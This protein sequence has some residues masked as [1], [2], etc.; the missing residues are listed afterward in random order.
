VDITVRKLFSAPTQ[1][2]PESLSIGHNLIQQE[3][4]A[5]NNAQKTTAHGK[6]AAGDGACAATFHACDCRG[7][8]DSKRTAR[9]RE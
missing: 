6:H 8:G 4:I 9:T 7:L 5:A 2:A 1:W 3:M